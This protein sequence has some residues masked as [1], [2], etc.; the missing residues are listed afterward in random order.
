MNAVIYARVSS[1]EQVS[2]YSIEAQIDQ[3]RA[4]AN[5]QG[6]RVV[7]VYIE[8][9]KS[10]RTDDRPVFQRMI[11]NVCA[12]EA[13]AVVVHKVDRFA[14]NLLD[15]LRY[16]RQ[17]RDD[18]VRLLSVSEEFL[19]GDSPENDLATKILGAVAEYVAYN[20]GQEAI[21]GQTAKA[22]SGQ[23]PG[24]VVPLGYI[25]I[26]QGREAIID[27]CPDYGPIIRTAYDDF[28]SGDYTIRQ[29]VA[30]ARGRGYRSKKGKVIKGSTWH[31]V[32]RSVFYIGKFEWQGETYDGDHP[33]LV[34]GETWQ[35]VQDAL[36]ARASGGS[37]QRHFWLLRGLLWSEMYARAMSGNL[38]K[39]KYPYYRAK[40]RNSEEHNIRAEEAEKQVIDLLATIRADGQT[41]TAPDDLRLA[42]L[43]APHCGAVYA[44]LPTD[45]A[46]RD[47]LQSIFLTHG[48]H[49]NAA[50]VVSV[51]GLRTGFKEDY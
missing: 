3:C 27:I 6:Y 51:W 7:R 2:G 35:A 15:L 40:G 47:F 14:R 39:G 19:N 13:R 20:I 24:A 31:N 8:P 33:A 30:E 50:G 36:E 32:F 23:W 25:R 26:G 42:L 38:A 16:K 5:E 12:G 43:S 48:L 45:Q 37:Q 44:H 29:W 46:R 17:L 41:V 28:A 11:K 22:K 4:W 21:K 10:A 34:D 1:V 49:V 18:G 9:G